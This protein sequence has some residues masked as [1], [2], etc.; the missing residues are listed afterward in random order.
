MGKCTVTALSLLVL[1][2]RIYAAEMIPEPLFILQ[3][4]AEFISAAAISPDKSM[5]VSAEAWDGTVHL[6]DLAAGNEVAAIETGLGG[7]NS[8]GFT[9]DGSRF[10]AAGHSGI[11]LWDAQSRDVWK[12]I[13]IGMN[14]QL[15]IE[16][17]PRDFF[18]MCQMPC[19]DAS[20]TLWNAIEGECEPIL[21]FP[22]R[23]SG[24]QP[25][26]VMALSPD[27][28]KV[29]IGDE[30]GGRLW[31]ASEGFFM[32][33]LEVANQGVISGA[34]L[35]DDELLLITEGQSHRG[36]VEL[37]DANTGEIRERMVVS[38]RF[39]ASFDINTTAIA[40]L[41]RRIL[42]RGKLWDMQLARPGSPDEFTDPAAELDIEPGGIRSADL[43]ADGQLAVL[44]HDDGLI[45]VWD[46]SAA[47]LTGIEDYA[48]HRGLLPSLL[49]AFR[50]ALRRA[51]FLDVTAG[52]SAVD[53]FVDGQ[54]Q[55]AGVL[56]LDVDLVWRQV[57]AHRFVAEFDGFLEVVIAI[58]Q[59]FLRF[60]EFLDRG[61]GRLQLAVRH[62]R[63]YAD[64]HLLLH[65]PSD[66]QED[67][68]S[69]QNEYDGNDRSQLV[70]EKVKQFFH[71]YSPCHIVSVSFPP[72]RGDGT[73]I[74]NRRSTGPHC[75]QKKNRFAIVW[76]SQV[77]G[78]SSRFTAAAV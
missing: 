4:G 55:A 75:M 64:I 21:E 37:F 50:L 30:F 39:S 18:L 7:I 13:P 76:T 42:I 29:V 67:A 20:I 38:G 69:N 14:G 27:G 71:V 12:S 1:G 16:F 2:S 58:H 59:E 46:L 74:C 44:G 43:S 54:Q 9:N 61:V 10:F 41:T 65:L 17:C 45:T 36:H 60:F 48:K 5:L 78:K 24:F 40:P 19:G 28:T 52:M 72:Q 32:K 26:G 57:L 68:E 62:G 49:P 70:L 3:G 47:G 53:A 33:M 25:P 11:V 66:L 34:F 73:V 22:A 51:G 56:A 8:V 35:A 23:I 15:Y 63:I 31:S 6:W 77:L